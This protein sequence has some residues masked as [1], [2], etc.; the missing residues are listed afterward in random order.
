[1]PKIRLFLHLSMSVHVALPNHP[2]KQVDLGD[3]RNSA[4]LAIDSFGNDRCTVPLE[5][6]VEITRVLNQPFCPRRLRPD[7]GVQDP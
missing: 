5:K 2:G 6:L 4:G 1:M 3:N 7:A